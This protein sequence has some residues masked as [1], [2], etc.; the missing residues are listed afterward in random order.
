[1]GSTDDSQKVL[2]EHFRDFIEKEKEKKEILKKLEMSKLEE[3]MEK[4]SL[5]KLPG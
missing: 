4:R 1:M 3:E 5:R 2:D